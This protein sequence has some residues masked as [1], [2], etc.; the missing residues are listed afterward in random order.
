MQ[1]TADT[2]F[3]TDSG[4]ESPDGLGALCGSEE[5]EDLLDEINLASRAAA[6]GLS[7]ALLKSA[8]RGL[9]SGLVFW[10]PPFFITSLW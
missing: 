3:G 1:A 4:F 7:R 2:F 8:A 9:A 10:I 5:A 6:A